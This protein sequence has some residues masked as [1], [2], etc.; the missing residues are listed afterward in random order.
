[1]AVMVLVGIASLGALFM[2]AF[3]V[4]IDRGGAHRRWANKESLTMLP[5]KPRVGPRVVQS[6]SRRKTL[7]MPLR[8]QTGSV[9]P[10]PLNERSQG[11]VQAR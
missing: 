10:R 1:M 4:M 7:R 8:T 3:L 6:A 2:V 11:R 9:P 5:P